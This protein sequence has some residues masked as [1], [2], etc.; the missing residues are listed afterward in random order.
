MDVL[1]PSK[2]VLFI[3]FVIPGFVSLKAYEALGLGSPRGTNQQI[4]DAIA[5]SCLNYAILSVAI[6]SVESF[7]LRSRSPWIYGAFWFFVLFV[8]P[9][10]LTCA[11]WMLRH[12]ELVLKAIPHPVGKPWDFVF[13]QRRPYWVIVRLKD[14]SKIAG[15]YDSDSF[16]SSSPQ[17][18]QI[19]LQ[20][21]WHLN[22]DGGFDRA[23]TDTAGIIL[24]GS[25][26]VAIELF[27]LTRRESN[28]R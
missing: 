19:Y 10:G 16:A 4:I 23:R 12:S 5:Y 13:S 8:A 28:E 3:A 17:P 22:H 6:I 11:V 24:L 25:E 21:A 7:G 27:H 20:E 18:E 14:G 26:I 2:L 1:D 15:R 9:I